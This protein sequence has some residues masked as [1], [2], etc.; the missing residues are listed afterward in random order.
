MLTIAVCR[1]LVSFKGSYQ[2]ISR[3]QALIHQWE[4]QD[5]VELKGVF[6]LGHC[7]GAVAVAQ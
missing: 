2:V 6:C 1:Q 7:T 4:L 5:K 3:F